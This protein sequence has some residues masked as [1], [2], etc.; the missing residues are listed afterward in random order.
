MDNYHKIPLNPEKRYFVVGDIHGRYATFLNLLEEIEYNKETDIICSVGDLIDR[1]P[2]SVEVVEFFKQSNTYAVLGN[3]EQMVNNPQDWQ[4]CW[5]FP[6]NGG[7]AT[8]ASLEKHGH[9]I[10]WLQRWTRSLPI[11][12]DVGE[13]DDPG[14]F[15]VVHAECPIMWSEEFFH[16]TMQLAM[17]MDLAEGELTWGRRTISRAIA[18]IQSMSPAATGITFNENFTKRNVF[19]G[20]TPTENV[21]RVHNMWWIDTFRSRTMSMMNA[22]TLDKYFVDITNPYPGVQ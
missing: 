8:M 17:P 6:P 1:G 20:H 7:P 21:V 4:A 11:V 14:A 16:E 12:L 19:C 10:A 13:D 9:D 22:V 15:R 3:H 5:M 18:N 2:E